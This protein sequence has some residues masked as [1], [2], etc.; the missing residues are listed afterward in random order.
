MKNT[1]KAAIYGAAGAAAGYGIAKYAKTSKKT[2]L[3]LIIGLA[4]IGAL[5]GNNS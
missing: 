1:K 5:V 4:V 2:T 3:G